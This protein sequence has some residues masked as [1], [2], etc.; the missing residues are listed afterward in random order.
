[1]LTIFKNNSSFKMQ[2]K[3]NSSV[4]GVTKSPFIT[5]SVSLFAI[6]SIP[7]YIG[8]ISLSYLTGADAAVQLRFLSNMNM[9]PII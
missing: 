6:P 4:P 9:I 8:Y 5:L 3:T 1:M 2:S 7:Y